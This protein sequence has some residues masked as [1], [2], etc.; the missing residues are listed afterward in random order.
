MCRLLAYA[1]VRDAPVAELLGAEGF[2]SLEA[3]SSLHGDGWGMA[4]T[5]DGPGTGASAAAGDRSIDTKRSTRRALDDPSFHALA[6]SALGR[7]GLVHLRWA[8]LGFEVR[9][10][11]THPFLC[12]GWAFAHNGSIPAVDRLDGLLS[13]AYRARRRGDTD[14]ERYFLHVLERIEATGDVVAAICEAVADIRRVCGQG[15]LNAVLLSPMMLAVVHG[16]AGTPPPREHLL[17]AVG[18]PGN[19]PIGHLDQYYDLRY[20]CRQDA[21]VV[22][23]TGIVGEDWTDV[24]QDSV[25]IIDYLQKLVRVHDLE[26]PARTT[27]LPFPAP[28]P[29]APTTVPPAEPDDVAAPAERGYVKS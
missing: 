20:R 22:A 1:S 19:L 7:S 10:E 11:N 21:V 24:P 12:D 14:S 13:P 29:A 17:A 3:L 15:S 9:K 16:R 2:G 6:T 8:T 28:A 26:D 18:D 5:A 25:L 4:W 23:S 27:E